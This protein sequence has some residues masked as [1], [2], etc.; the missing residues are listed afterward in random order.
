MSKIEVNLRHSII[1]KTLRKRPT[2]YDAINDKL[3]VEGQLLSYN[4]SCSKR[5]LQRDI[6]HIASYFD[7]VI[8]YNSSLQAYEIVEDHTDAHKERMLETFDL[9]T[10]L[11]LSDKISSRM[12]VESRKPSG[13]HHFHLLLHAI[14]NNQE[15]TFKH[16]KF[17]E[18]PAEP[19]QRT[20]QPIALKEARNRWYL[21][22]KDNKDKLIKTFG[23]DRISELYLTN[24]H[25]MP[26]K[27]Y[28]PGE[29][30]RYC[31]G[32][33]GES[34]PPSEKII[35]SLTPEQGK[36]IQSLPLHHSQQVLVDTDIE[37]RIE[38]H[39][40]PTYDFVME[41]L[42]LGEQVKVLQPES[43]KNELLN[44]LKAAV[45]RYC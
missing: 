10:A 14:E 6:E 17:W 27:D 8:K 29:A 30:F 40:H 36:Y 34:T 45:K 13:T 15:I 5:T 41:L 39:L 22:A 31:F 26:I 7:I 1:I 42:S 25:F 3:K 9:M 44:K 21:I 38:L 4:L 19:T 32:V 23:L 2:D 28:N 18:Q 24:R 35:L 11:N 12:L 37:C 33:I 20:V 16:E 43:L